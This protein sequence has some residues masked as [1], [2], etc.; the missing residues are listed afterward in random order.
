MW[1]FNYG[2]AEKL[3]RCRAGVASQLLDAV[4]LVH[5]DPG[6]QPVVPKRAVIL[7][8][9]PEGRPLVACSSISGY[10]QS[11]ARGCKGAFPARGF[12]V[13]KTLL[14]IDKSIGIWGNSKA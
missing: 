13:T 6:F 14:A 9:L 8:G 7:R 1:P 4:K 10:S 3:R 5:G 12:R 11:N 2:S